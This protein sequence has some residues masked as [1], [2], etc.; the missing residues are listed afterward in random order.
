MLPWRVVA[1]GRVALQVAERLEQD[2]RDNHDD[3]YR[4]EDCDDLGPARIVRA[5]MAEEK[6]G[7]LRSLKLVRLDR[8]AY[9]LRNH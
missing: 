2:E 7:S 9:L 6:A 4:N 5:P 8:S 1:S 3:Q